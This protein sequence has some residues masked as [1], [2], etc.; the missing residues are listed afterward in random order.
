MKKTYLL[1]FAFLCLGITIA[2]AQFTKLLDFNVTNGNGPQADL[3][4]SGSKLYGMTENGG[5]HSGGVIFSLN[6]DG[7]G[8]RDLFD[9]DSA[10][11]EYPYGSLTLAGNVLYGMTRYGGA[12][13][14][15][16]VFSIHTDGTGYK[17]MID[18]NGSNGSGPTG[19]LLLIGHK[20]YGM[21][22]FGGS[23]SNGVMFS[24]DTNG[25][26]NTVLY[27]FTGGTGGAIS[28][29]SLILSGGLFYGM[30]GYGGSVGH[31]NIFS[32]DTNGS[33]YMDLL[34]FNSTDGA[35]P[36]GSL[37]QSGNVLYGMAING[38]NIYGLGT[39]F[40]VHT[41]GSHEKTLIVFN[42]T[43]GGYPNGSL[44]L[45]GS[46]L[47]GMTQS[48]GP[49]GGVVFSIDTNGNNSNIF[50]LTSS[51]G[52]TP[53]GS[54]IHSGNLL[55]GMTSGGGV[56]GVGT[57]FKYFDGNCNLNVTI[58]TTNLTCFGA[59]NG[60]ETANVTGG[61]SPFTYTWSTG[62]TTSSITGLPVGLY[63]VTVQDAN[64]C[65]FST[66]Y[67][68]MNQPSLL[69]DSISESPKIYCNGGTTTITAHPYGGTPI[70][71]YLWSPGGN[72]NSNLTG[73]S[74]GSYTV[75]VT[76]ANGC[77]VTTSINVTPPAKLRDS[78]ASFTNVLC[79]GGT[80][81]ATVGAKYGTAPYT[82]SWNPGG[83]TMATATGLTAGIYTVTVT[84]HNGC[85]ATASVT[86]TQPILLSVTA[87]GSNVSCNGGNNGTGTVTQ[88]G[89]TSPYTYLW[90]GGGTNNTKTGMT[91][92]SYTV[93]V[94]DHNG[95]TATV[96]I[97]ITQPPLLTATIIITSNVTCNGYNTGILTA[98]PSGGTPIYTYLWSPGGET[99][100]TATGLSAG[101]YTLTVTDSHGCTATTNTIITQ[102]PLLT[103]TITGTTNVSCAVGNNGTITFSSG[104]GTP[105]YTYLWNP[106]GGTSDPATG[107]TA[108][109]YTVKVT[110]AN[111]CIA[112]ASATITQ[113]P[114]LAVTATVTAEVSC[115]GG[116]NGSAAC[117]A[118]GG[119]S[120]FTYSWSGGGSNS[121][122]TGMSAGTYT[123][124]IHD[125]HGCLATA[126]VTVTQPPL[127]HD[128][129]TINANVS[130]HGGSNGSVTANVT[131]G[132]LPYTYAWAPIGATTATA[133]GL[134]AGTYT[135]TATDSHGC[136]VTASVTITQPPV[137][138]VTAT[139]TANVSC[140]GGNN[141]SI[142]S[143]ATGGTPAY[144]YLWSPGGATTASASGLTAG[145][146]TETVTDKH[147]CTATATATITQP[148]LLKDSIVTSITVNNLCANNSSGSAKVGVRGG[149]SPYTYSW[150]NGKTTATITGLSSGSYTATVK[151]HNGCSHAATVTITSPATV[152]DSAIM[153]APL[154][155]GNSNGSVTIG[156]KG[157]MSPYTFAWSPNTNTNATVTNLSSGSFTVTVNDH[158]G[159]SST[160]SFTLTQPAIIRDSIKSTGL[161]CGLGNNGTAS[162]GVKG[163][164]MPYTYHWSPGGKTTAAVTGLSAGTYSLTVTDKNGCTGTTATLTIIQA[165][166]IRD[167][168]STSSCVVHKANAT[169]GVK[170]GVAPYTYLWTPSGGTTATMTGL[171]NGTYTITVTDKNGCS[172]SAVKSFLCPGVLTGIDNSG[173]GSDDFSVYPNPNTGV[174]TVSFG[175]AE[176][177]S[178][179]HP[180]VEV[181]DELGQKV[182]ITTLKQVK[183]DY[184]IN[185]SS[186]PNGIYLIRILDKDGNL[187][188]QKKVVKTN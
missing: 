121:T 170:G 185:I 6:T 172:A 71:T 41:D 109:T 80:G 7:S 18:F 161:I 163:G 165:P 33:G 180:I 17:R 154:C 120:P 102:P 138:A 57:V 2:K 134:S 133:T 186:K 64:G 59:N 9:L 42:D 50:D 35:R 136:S 90:S 76:D 103:L 5:A 26:A 22:G 135:N 144:T 174:F 4:L 69:Q 188:G 159:C 157:G 86:L 24:M 39:L 52:T 97:T 137:L 113:P 79:H 78:I 184:I 183:G 32:I 28:E 100:A 116:N 149:V 61:T 31:G 49:A 141:G 68:M 67:S 92:G 10:H 87:V 3:T 75:T 122:K 131:G 46:T 146:Y 53:M 74:S 94:T 150:S 147:G 105:A 160:V 23:S 1:F 130:C 110:D 119:T 63:S 20:L 115:N 175:H 51:D 169:L 55:Y 65:S 124:T 168:I 95:C 72:T 73:L 108:G 89:G 99:N 14:I 84:D 156:V 128:T 162:A 16:V 47:Y 142:S 85:T 126:T 98:N 125:L 15:G 106:G 70:Y 152:R 117:T 82:Y 34:D 21:T 132:T 143:T 111:G 27:N 62:M 107:L 118:T 171:S 43:N 140:N 178:A 37:I 176:L 104:G 139:V 96:A 181:Y 11:G 123:I 155:F 179:S 8:Y 54:F 93:T 13:N 77:T 101:S 48:G 30:T 29:G 182:T 112:T 173:S 45:I 129:I 148:T 40:S 177:V 88:S 158:N 91:A 58:T 153:T 127:M 83:N 66:G 60:I 44:N 187:V 38:G 56:N 166:A 167:S 114:V 81:T 19:A 12:H 145:T 151:D 36:L 25:T 164:T